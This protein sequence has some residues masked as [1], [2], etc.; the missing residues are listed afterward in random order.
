[1][2]KARQLAAALRPTA[3]K[4]TPNVVLV[5]MVILAKASIAGRF[6]LAGLGS[7]SYG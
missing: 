1:M 6:W 2:E 3:K 4:F 5:V 7:L